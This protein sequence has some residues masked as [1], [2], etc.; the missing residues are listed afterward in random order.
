MSATYH[1]ILTGGVGSRLWPL[2]RKS[3]PKQYLELFKNDSLFELAIK[4][5]QKFSDG[6]IVVGNKDNRSLSISSLNKLGINSYHEIVE[7][8]PR[9]TAP[10]IAFAAFQVKPEDILVVTPADHIIKADKNYDHAVSKAIK[11]AQ[12][13]NIVT[14]GVTPTRPETGYG[15]IES[16]G[17]NVVSFREK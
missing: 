7:A 8:T 12:E 2:S 11:L 15:Y 10:A 16:E 4:R 14:F 6:L 17:Q 1:V 3:Q 5:N 13:G 9:N